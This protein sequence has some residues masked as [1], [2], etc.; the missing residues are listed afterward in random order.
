MSGFHAK[1]AIYTYLDSFPSCIMSSVCFATLAQS[2][3]IYIF[4]TGFIN[5]DFNYFSKVSTGIYTAKHM[6]QD[7]I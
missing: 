7:P 6:S 4:V 1:R 5:K 3:K 2:I